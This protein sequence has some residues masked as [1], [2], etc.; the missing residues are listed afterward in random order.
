MESLNEMGKFAHDLGARVLY[1]ISPLVHNMIGEN[2]KNSQR[3]YPKIMNAYSDYRDFFK[4]DMAGTPEIPDFAVR[5]SHGL[6]HVDHRLLDEHAQEM[7]VIVSCSIAKSKIFV[8]PFNKWNKLTEKICFE[9]GIE[10][11]KFEDGWKCIE[12]NSFDPDQKL[13]YIHHRE[14][15]VE[16]FKAWFNA[17]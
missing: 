8:P 4:V 12:Y 5:A 3:I 10:L 16:N 11:V 2:K 15:S 7:S 1:C 14:L 6:I 9:N 17:K 13:W